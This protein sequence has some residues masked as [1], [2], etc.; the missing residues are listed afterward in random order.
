MEENGFI[1]VD[2]TADKAVFR[3]F[4]YNRHEPAENIDRLEPFRLV[5]MERPG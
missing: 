1:L 2:F 5:E 4:K 3:F